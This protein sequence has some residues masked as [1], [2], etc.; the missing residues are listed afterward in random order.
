MPKELFP[1]ESRYPKHVVRAFRSVKA[2]DLAP[3]DR[4]ELGDVVGVRVM[5]E[6]EVQR[7]REDTDLTNALQMTKDYINER[8]PKE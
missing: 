6:E 3:L 5:L 7:N 8:S 2:H 1:I 4:L